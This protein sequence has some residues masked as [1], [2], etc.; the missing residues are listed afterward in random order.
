MLTGLK[1]RLLPVAIILFSVLTALLSCVSQK[2][3]TSPQALSSPDT[4]LES[5]TTVISTAAKTGPD[6]PSVLTRNCRYGPAETKGF[7]SVGVKI[8][9]KAVDFALLDTTGREF[10][11]S[12]LLAEKPVVLIFGSF[13]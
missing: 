8:G 5:R 2:D 1:R 7:E 10:R 13:T 11:L 12:R 9:E 4:N 3:L 6:L